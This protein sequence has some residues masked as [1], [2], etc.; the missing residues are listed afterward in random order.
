LR[1][2]FLYFC[3]FALWQS[4]AQAGHAGSIGRGVAHAIFSEVATAPSPEVPI[5]G[6]F[7]LKVGLERPEKNA[8]FLLKKQKKQKK[9]FFVSVSLLNLLGRRCS[10]YFSFV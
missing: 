5:H 1:G 9:V 8:C 10:F 7:A 3:Y 2:F 6:Y 4:I